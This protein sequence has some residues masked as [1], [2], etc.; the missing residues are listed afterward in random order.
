[1]YEDC[2]IQRHKYS[3]DGREYIVIIFPDGSK[4]TTNFARYLMEVKLGRLLNRNE[5]V[6]HIDGNCYNDCLDN[7]E[8]I[9]PKTHQRLHHLLDRE[10]EFS[11]YWCKKNLV[12]YGN[13]LTNYLR[14]VKHNPTSKGPFCDATCRAKYRANERWN[15]EPIVAFKGER[16]GI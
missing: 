6:H 8:L 13:A 2:R 14:R 10:Q 7:L 15:F 11:C 3:P 1:M 16:S 4:K 12:L 9:D 5:H